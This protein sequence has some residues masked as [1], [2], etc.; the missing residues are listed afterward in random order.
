V[1]K[2]I[3]L[4]LFVG[5]LVA[6]GGRDSGTLYVSWWGGDPRHA[7]TLRAIEAF[8]LQ[9][10]GVEI[11]SEYGAWTG[12]TDRIGIQLSGG[13]AG[14]LI[15]INHN[16]IDMFSPSGNTFYD[17]NRLGGVLDLSGFSP[18]VLADV[19]VNNRLQMA[20]MGMTGKVFVYNTTRLGE[21]GLSMPNTWDEMIA[22]GNALRALD[23]NNF[24]LATNDEDMAFGV[25]SYWLLQRTGREFLNAQG[26]INYSV[27]ELTEAF[28]FLGR[29][30]AAHV[31]FPSPRIASA[32]V[33]TNTIETMPGWM[34][35]NLI[36]FFGWDTTVARNRGTLPAGSVLEVG[37][38]PTLAGAVQQNAAPAKISL[39]FAINNASNAGSVNWAARLLNFFINEPEGVLILGDTRGIPGNSRTIQ[40]LNGAGALDGNITALA[41][42]AVMANLGYMIPP[43]IEHPR[44]RDFY[45]EVIEQFSFGLVNA[46]QAATRFLN[47]GNTLLNSLRN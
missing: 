18:T 36:G 43:I 22:L 31:I 46:N 21:L 27:A 10:P 39:G 9:N 38:F 5:A 45:Y 44:F 14:D 40:I 20:P 29:L 1:V 12:W 33:R 35:G 8:Q 37:P 17:L 13:T 16:W 7:A 23:D 32:G 2:K 19:T 30:E 4:S 26:A 6:C 25:M 42:N 41:N 47:E 24:I 15:Q 34:N 3:L 11:E 28:E